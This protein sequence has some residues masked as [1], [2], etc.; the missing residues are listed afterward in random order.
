MKKL[1][2]RRYDRVRRGRLE[3]RNDLFP[4]PEWGVCVYGSGGAGRREHRRPR[5][6]GIL[7]KGLSACSG[8]RNNPKG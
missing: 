7:I 2:I 1:S 4:E 6:T 8:I 3:P 5:T